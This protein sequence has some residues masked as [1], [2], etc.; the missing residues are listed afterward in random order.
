M[1]DPKSVIDT[2][3][4][5][6]MLEVIGDETVG[7]AKVTRFTEVVLRSVPVIWQ[8]GVWLGCEDTV[9]EREREREGSRV[10]KDRVG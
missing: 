6:A 2:P 9:R 1:F 10:E 3:P 7:A 5:W 4:V 8:R